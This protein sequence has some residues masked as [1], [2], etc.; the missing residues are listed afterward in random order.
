MALK[1]TAK[2]EQRMV[3]TPQLRQRIEML[4]MTSLELTDLVQT[5]LLSNPILEEVQSQDEVKEISEEFLDQYA[6]GDASDNTNGS[7]SGEMPDMNTAEQIE[8]QLGSA[9]GNG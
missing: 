4:Q 5:E 9:N 8:A 1:L 7:G 3:L 2:L 6:T